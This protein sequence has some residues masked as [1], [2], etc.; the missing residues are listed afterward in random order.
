MWRCFR[1][2]VEK[3]S[4]S[5][6]LW[7]ARKNRGQRRCTISWQNI[8]TS[9]WATSRRSISS[10]TTR[11][12]PPQSIMSDYTNIIRWL[13]HQP[14]LVIAHQV[15]FISSRRRNGFG[16]TTRKSNWSFSCAILSSAHLPIGTYKDRNVVPYERV[17]NWEE[18][19][20]L[21]NL[22]ADDIAKLEQ[23]LG[24][25]CSNWKL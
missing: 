11:P 5:I 17:M 16:N 13:P 24:W 23:M 4:D 10:M 25:D 7:Q 6:S 14:W 20:F 19:I 22:F 2:D 9:P 18:R 8:Q 3:S 21:Y 1:P 12:S 15:T